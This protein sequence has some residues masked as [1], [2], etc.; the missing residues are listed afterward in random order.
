MKCPPTYIARGN[1]NVDV[2]ALRDKK[3]VHLVSVVEYR[4]NNLPSPFD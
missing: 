1:G 3:V 4:S 2:T